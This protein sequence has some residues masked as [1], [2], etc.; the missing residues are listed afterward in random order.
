MSIPMDT[1]MRHTRQTGHLSAMFN[2]HE[3]SNMYKYDVSNRHRQAYRHEI[4]YA[5]TLTYMKSVTKND[6]IIYETFNRRTITID[7]RIHYH[8]LPISNPYSLK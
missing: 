7:R 8:R 5:L 2:E 4:N 3:A 1:F 6:I